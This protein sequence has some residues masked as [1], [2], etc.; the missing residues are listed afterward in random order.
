VAVE[1]KESE[2]TYR[3]GSGLNGVEAEM[4]VKS[5]GQHGVEGRR[6][7]RTKVQESIR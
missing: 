4:E 6:S 2:L 1:M 5:L 7:K 3:N